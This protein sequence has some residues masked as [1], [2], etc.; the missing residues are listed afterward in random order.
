MP[1]MG[2]HP[3]LGSGLIHSGTHVIGCWCWHS[4]KLTILGWQT[5]RTS[6]QAPEP[7]SRMSCS[8]HNSKAAAARWKLCES[9]CVFLHTL[10]WIYILMMIITEFFRILPYK[11]GWLW[12]RIPGLVILEQSILEPLWIHEFS[13][14]SHLTL[15]SWSRSFRC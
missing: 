14:N 5:H 10:K 6:H 11:Q 12:R 1:C 9:C 3:P 13:I 8:T 2:D 7:A 4:V 15:K